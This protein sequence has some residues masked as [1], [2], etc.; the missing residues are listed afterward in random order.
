MSDHKA[1]VE[2]YIE[3]FR[4]TNHHAIPG[5][6]TDDVL[7]VIHGHR[8]LRGK[9]AFDAEI[10]NEAA[11]GS[12]SLHLDHL[13]EEGDIVVAV[14]HGEMTLKDAGPVAFVFTEIFTFTGSLIRR[15]DTF[16]INTGESGDNSSR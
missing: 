11:V 12:P 5:C 8:T 9:E 6:L 15:I 14:G 2:D 4:R 16:H 7:W 10:E 3:G 13:I 1:V